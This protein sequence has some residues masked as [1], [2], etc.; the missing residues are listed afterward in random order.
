[1]TR[2]WTALPSVPDGALL[3]IAKNELM[4]FGTFS[5]LRRTAYVFRGYD[6]RRR[7]WLRYNLPAQPDR[8]GHVEATFLRRPQ[9][10]ASFVPG[11]LFR[12]ADRAFVPFDV[13][14]PSQQHAAIAITSSGVVAF[15]PLPQQEFTAGTCGTGGRGGACDPIPMPKPRKAAPRGVILPWVESPGGTLIPDVLGPGR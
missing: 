6:F 11:Y 5:P 3:T 2:S 13:Q 9:V 1:V 8:Q 4:L 12:Q 15:G 7:E 14:M 10:L